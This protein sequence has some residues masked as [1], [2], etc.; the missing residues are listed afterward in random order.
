M[1]SKSSD[2]IRDELAKYAAK[3][4]EDLDSRKPRVHAAVVWSY[5]D[6]RVRDAIAARLAGGEVLTSSSQIVPDRALRRERVYFDF[7]PQGRLDAKSPGIL[8]Q[9][10]DDNSVAEILDPFDPQSDTALA[11]A[12]SSDTLPLFAAQATG[13]RQPDKSGEGEL[14]LRW[15]RFVEQ[16]D[17]ARAFASRASGLF[18]GLFGGGFGVE[19][20]D[21][22]CGGTP[23]RSAVMSEAGRKEDPDQ[24]TQG[25]YFDD[26]PL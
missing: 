7:C 9:I 21:T 3:L 2:G 18:G 22:L 13:R 10:N 12:S 8:V 25:A 4:K 24:D 23:T 6:S 11:V 1:T 15:T 5:Q 14:R 26:C 20:T 17:I 16:P 19:A